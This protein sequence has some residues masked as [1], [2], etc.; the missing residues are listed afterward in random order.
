MAGEAKFDKEHVD[1][2]VQEAER[3]VCA[4]V[5]EVLELFNEGLDDF[6][7][8]GKALLDAIYNEMEEAL[9]YASEE[10]AGD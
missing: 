10:V 8:G 5:W 9:A 6:G 2:E 3:R 1:H 4:K 7:E